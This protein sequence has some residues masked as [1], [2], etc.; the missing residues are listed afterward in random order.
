MLEVVALS[1]L[2]AFLM[3]V[4][5]GAAGEMGKQLLLS[6][7][8]LVRRTTGGRTPLPADPEE[9]AALAGVLHARMG[10][11]PRL[12]GEWALLLRAHGQPGMPV[13]TRGSGLPPA[14]RHFTNRQKTLR[15]LAREATRPADG[16]PRVALLHGPPGIGTTAAALR[17][18]AEQHGRFPD[19]QFYVD[20]RD[21]AA[22]SGPGPGAVLS[23]L[24]R[25]MLAGTASLPA[26]EADREE[27][28]RRVTADRRALVVVD[29]A[30]SL[31]QVRGLVPSTPGVFLIVVVS[32]QPFALEAERVEVEP[33]SDRYAVRMLR[34]LAGRDKVARARARMPHLLGQCAGNAFALKAAA[35]RLRSEQPAD[36]P[37][38]STSAGDPL[39]AAV[40]DA[41]ARLRP[42]T[43]RLCRLA[44]LGAWPGL[45][46]HLAAAA[47]HV[48]PAEAA[49]MLREAVDAQLLDL[50]PDE[51]HRF[52]PEVRRY[53]SDTAGPELGIAECSAAVRRSLDAVLNR[54]LHAAHAALP[55]S[56]R[57][58][59]APARGT[60]YGSESEGLRALRA[61]VDN[62]VRAVFLAEEYGHIDTALRLARA[63]WP[64]QLKAG[65]WDDVRPALRRAARLADAE[66][67]HTPMA[68]ALHLQLAHCL[69][70]LGQRGEA[71]D[72]ARAALECERTSG[73]LRGEASVVEMMG[74]FHLSRWDYTAAYERFT[75]AR[76]IYERIRPGDEGTRDLPRAFALTDRHRGRALRGM[77]RLEESQRLLGT[78]VD[79][80]TERGEP[81]NTARAL[82]DL[83][84]TLHDAGRDTE[85]LTRITE[86]ERLLDPAAEPHR[87]YLSALR[88]RCEGGA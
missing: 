54:A 81:Y 1:A 85:A 58:E 71:D 2:T 22:D 37:P 48:T 13:L 76:G 31:A 88:S 80:F 60:P 30:T 62:V 51:R 12:A 64:L 23:R 63:L 10:Q 44:A 87:Q 69:E 38:T 26:T 32:G 61:E 78:A 24:L 53:L 47:A 5:N 19:G 9:R 46:A 75:E 86:A 45:D 14:P 73:H 56:W 83:A 72:A 65:H 6:T 8:A 40:R 34:E 77:G 15:Q 25:Q 36:P 70:Q 82:T 84:E 11:D 52:R 43:A 27:L 41:T 21:T 33:L 55:E 50:L 66:Q 16:R 4:G 57:T 79:F 68:G 67:P 74:L 42:P 59:P 49:G 3:S 29:H 28:Y 20:L 39:H 35:L 18:G 7:G 17:L